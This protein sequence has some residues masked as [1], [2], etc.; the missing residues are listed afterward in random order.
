MTEVQQGEQLALAETEL[1]LRQQQKISRLLQDRQEQQEA[2]IS[3]QTWVIGLSGLVIAIVV[4]LTLILYRSNKERQHVNRELEELNEVKDKM[5]AV[6]AHDLRS[7]MTSMQGIFYLLKT[8]ALPM[9][10]IKELA[11]ELEVSTRQNIAMM[12]NLLS[13]TNSQMSGLDVDIREVSAFDIVQEVVDNSKL[14]ANH[15]SINLANN[16]DEDVQVSA[17]AN[18]LKLIIRNLINN[19]I[20]F[21]NEGDA[22]TIDAEMQN[23]NIVFKVKDT[24]IGISQEEQDHLFSTVGK[25]RSGT[26]NEK[27]SGLGLQLCKEFAEKQNG[28]IRLESTKG[29]GTTFYINLPKGDN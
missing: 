24:G 14:Q 8:E 26:R 12:D 27:G 5:M 25:S 18:L 4:G 1:G 10:E 19:A 13:W 7:P 16:V 15:K 20:K 6:I 2:R 11:A 21:S 9:D 22:V 23:G 29:E 3:A 28:G 17:D